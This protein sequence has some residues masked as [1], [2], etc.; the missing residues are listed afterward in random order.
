MNSTNWVTWC[1]ADRLTLINPATGSFVQEQE[2][3][4][5]ERAQCN[6]QGLHP[7][8]AVGTC[9]LRRLTAVFGLIQL[10]EEEGREESH[11]GMRKRTANLVDLVKQK[12]TREQPTGRMRPY[13]VPSCHHIMT[14]K[15]VV[16]TSCAKSSQ[17]HQPSRQSGLGDGQ[18]KK[19]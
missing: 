8:V 18:V 7:P 6:G 4:G 14:R 9:W 16:K 10:R 2:E 1:L 17:M 13:L 3:G 11:A 19:D 12:S 15:P 5:A